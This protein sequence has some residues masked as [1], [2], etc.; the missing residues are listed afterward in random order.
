MDE[1]KADWRTR[2]VESFHVVLLGVGALLFVFG[3]TGGG[4]IKGLR[5][6][7]AS[8]VGQYICAGVGFALMVCG[9]G[10]VA[11]RSGRHATPPIKPEDFGITIVSPQRGDVVDTVDVRGTLQKSIPA[12]YTLRVLRMYPDNNRLFYPLQE[13][14]IAS[15]GRTWEALSCDIGGNP[16]DNRALAACLWSSRRS[17]LRVSR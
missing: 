5:L 17:A 13:A 6:S 2:I 16:G 10:L 3:I 1:T 14:I 7:I 9:V 12:G 15:D 11:W 4:E 8:P